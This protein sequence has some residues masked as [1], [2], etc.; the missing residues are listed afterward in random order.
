MPRSLKGQAAPSHAFV[1]VPNSASPPPPDLPSWC[2]WWTALLPQARVER[3]IREMEGVMEIDVTPATA[4]TQSPAA[5]ETPGAGMSQGSTTSDSEWL[6]PVVV[7]VLPPT[8]DDCRRL[9]ARVI[10][11]L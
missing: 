8:D 4:A 2:F 6:L 3:E 11:L 5:P 7:S 1:P 9:L 10:T